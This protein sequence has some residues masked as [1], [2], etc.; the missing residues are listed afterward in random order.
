MTSGVQATQ[1]V[2]RLFRGRSPIS[3]P[4]GASVAE[5]ARLEGPRALTA[6]P[7]VDSSLRGTALLHND[8]SPLPPDNAPNRVTTRLLNGATWCHG[9]GAECS[10]SAPGRPKQLGF[11]PRH[12]TEADST[13][14]AIR[15]GCRLDAGWFTQN[16]KPR[17]LEG[18][19]HLTGR[20]GRHVPLMLVSNQSHAP[21]SQ[22]HSPPHS[23]TIM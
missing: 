4:P 18:Q 19:A 5:P 14:L 13:R 23:V 21:G 16:H 22:D 15:K 20:R 17:G 11:L 7:W 12:V 1:R 6:A 8:M 2:P 10:G 9:H 3:A